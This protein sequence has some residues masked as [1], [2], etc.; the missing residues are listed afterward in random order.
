[1]VYPFSSYQLNNLAIYQ[2]DN[3]NLSIDIENNIIAAAAVIRT[4]RP[5]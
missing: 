5:K 1:M 2:F 3:G 4:I